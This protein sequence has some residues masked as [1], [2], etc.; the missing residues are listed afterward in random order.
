MSDQSLGIMSKQCYDLRLPTKLVPFSISMAYGL[1]P[2]FISVCSINY[3]IK[4][5][6]L[7]ILQQIRQFI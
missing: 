5:Y 3:K 4:I 2:V 6:I 1:L 7:L